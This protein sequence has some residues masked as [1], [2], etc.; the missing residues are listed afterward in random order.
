[1]IKKLYL[2]LALLLPALLLTAGNPD[3]QGESGA[4][5]L[6]L[7]P[8][9]PSAGLHS[10]TTSMVYGVEAMRI[11]PAGIGRMPGKTQVQIG[12]ALY[13]QG[14]DIGLNA[15]GLAQRI[16][17]NGTFGLS[18]M[19]VDFGD[20]PVTTVNQPEGTGTFLELSFFNLGL[21]YSHNFDDK[22]YVGFLVRGVSESTS[23]ISAFGLALDAGIQYV[24]GENKE[25]KFGISLRNI[26]N[27]MSYAGQGLATAGPA[28]DESNYSLTYNQRAAAFEMPS[29][30][31]IGISLDLL[32]GLERHRLTLVGNFTGSPFSRDQLGGGIEYSFNEVF[33][34]RGGYR[35]ELSSDDVILESLYSGPSAGASIQVPLSRE[36]NSSFSIDYGYR[37]TRV[38]DGTH[39]IGIR[40]D[41]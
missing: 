11:N 10:L 21:G 1:M 33:S 41:L 32:T 40:L 17:E 39:N 8:F 16:G 9:A 24:S 15:L 2:T 37:A 25:F 4:A 7:N 35:A 19:S 22:I 20:I 30:L 6:L 14:T 31:N 34:V 5:Q 38:F 3:R 36:T 23:N 29:Q 26:G 27:R 18:L 12:H 13:L 28:P